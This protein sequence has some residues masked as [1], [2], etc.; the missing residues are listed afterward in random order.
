MMDSLNFEEAKQLC[1]KAIRIDRKH[2]GALETRA[3]LALQEENAEDARK[4]LLRAIDV[5]PDDGFSKYMYLGQ[6]E[7]GELA[8]KYYAKGIEI[9]AKDAEA[10]ADEGEMEEL[11]DLTQQ[12]S[13]AF[14]ST[15][16][17][18]LTDLWSVLCCFVFF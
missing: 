2:A 13:V 9:M 6:I 7:G 15:A 5:E 8:A 1:D 11:A 10:L 4:L 14:C 12:I 16:E 3:L 17:L 18:Y